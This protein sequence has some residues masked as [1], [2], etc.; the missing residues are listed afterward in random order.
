MA[1]LFTGGSVPVVPLVKFRQDRRGSITIQ[2]MA[3]VAIFVLILSLSFQVWKV[4]SIKQSL[5][6]ATYQAARFLTLNG[7]LWQRH[8]ADLLRD[9]IRPLVNKELHNNTFVP[10]DSDAEVILYLDV[11]R[12]DWCDDR[13]PSTFR[14]L[15]TYEYSVPL[16]VLGSSPISEVL[17][18]RQEHSG[19]M[20]CAQ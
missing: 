17:V 9:V 13:N 3:Y 11:T 20:L 12:P 5:K 16:P 15:V 6:S 1:V 2:A 8:Q 14:L 7:L 18:L 19:R 10:E 4:L